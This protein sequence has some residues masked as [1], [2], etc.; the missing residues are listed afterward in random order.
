MATR[1]QGLQPQEPP[2][3][4]NHAPEA[5]AKPFYHSVQ[6]IAERWGCSDDKTRRELEKY[7]GRDGFM[8]LGEPHRRY[9]RKRAIIRILPTLLEQI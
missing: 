8:D 5:G 2:Q 6:S 3:I 9:K 1:P 7:R 4:I